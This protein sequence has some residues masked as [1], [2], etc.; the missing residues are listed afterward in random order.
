MTTPIIAQRRRTSRLGDDSSRGNS[1]FSTRLMNYELRDTKEKIIENDTSEDLFKRSNLNL[2]SLMS[3]NIVQIS[4]STLRKSSARDTESHPQQLARPNRSRNSFYGSRGLSLVGHSSASRRHSDLLLAQALERFKPNVR[5]VSVLSN[6]PEKCPINQKYP[7]KEE[8]FDEDVRQFRLINGIAIVHCISILSALVMFDIGW[9]KGSLEWRATAQVELCKA[10]VSL[11]TLIALVMTAL[12]RN[13]Q[14][15]EL[16]LPKMTFA[17][18]FEYSVIIIHV[19]PCTSKVLQGVEWL[20]TCN[21]FLFVRL[22]ILYEVCRVRSSLWRLRRINFDVRGDQ[23]KVTGF[24]YVKYTMSNDPIKFFSFS[25]FIL[26]LCLAESMKVFERWEQPELGLRDCIYYMIIV[27]TSVGLGDIYCTTWLGR[28]LTICCA[29]MGFVFLSICVGFLFLGIE[30]HDTELEIKENHLKILA[31][32]EYRTFSATII[33]RWYRRCK[34]TLVKS[35]SNFIT[36]QLL[37]SMDVTDAK[38]TIK[39]QMALANKQSNGLIPRQTHELV[40]KIDQD[41]ETILQKIT[42]LSA[43]KRGRNISARR[44]IPRKCATGHVKNKSDLF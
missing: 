13:A 20:D 38:K 10:I 2:P 31:L 43:R 1:K 11:C 34:G 25:S 35:T 9:D 32:I 3:G 5:K 41:I 12:V 36:D 42:L 30:L 18:F 4:S 7:R 19:P 39:Q 33:Q 21:I 26:M 16:K 15:D 17:L 23:S 28:G 6:H 29:C 22:Y 27:F 44:M 14:H 40:Q 37:N 8:L 24:Y